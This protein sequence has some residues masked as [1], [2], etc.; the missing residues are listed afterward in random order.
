MNNKKRQKLTNDS[1][2]YSKQFSL[3]NIIYKWL[4]LLK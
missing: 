1:I 3:N 2:Q 4:N